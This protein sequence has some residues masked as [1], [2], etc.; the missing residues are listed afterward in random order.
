[1]RAPVIHPLHVGDGERD[2]ATFVMGAPPQ[3]IT[4]PFVM[5]YVEA[6]G[7][8]I[9]VDTGVGSPEATARRHHPMSQG[10]EQTPLAALARL[11][12]RPEDID[13]VVNTHLHWD[14]CSNNHLF[15]RATIY[16]QRAEL[17]YALA[18]LPLHVW[19][20]DSDGLHE[21]SPLIPPFLRARL[22][23]IEG[24]LEIAPGVTI[25]HTPGHTPGLQSVVVRGASGRYVIASDNVPLLDNLPGRH[26]PYF[27]PNG[28]HVDLSAYYR[29]FER[30]AA[31]GATILP[32]HDPSVLDR[33]RY[34]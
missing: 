3:P 15:P 7:R 9:L 8:R 22:T 4:I 26:R 34:E 27:T 5:F 24:D 20:Y 29:S 23:L 17:Q 25:W 30:I 11:G 6:D 16:A 2:R 33:E 18:P 19:A 21:P 32:S 28:I 12:V 10:P 14:H 31:A 13:V 1:M